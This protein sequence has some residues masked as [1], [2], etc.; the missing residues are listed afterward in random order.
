MDQV[1]E[2]FEFLKEGDFEKIKNLFEKNPKLINEKDW[3]E[4][5]CLHIVAWSDKTE[6]NSVDIIEY[7]LQK[8]AN[9]DEKDIFKC[10]PL[11][12]ASST[13]KLDL[14]KFLINKRCLY[15]IKK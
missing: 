11:Y 15:F 4:Q 2:W 5:N 14:V 1:K 12:W 7:F 10:T 6:K 3:N 9:I 13:G 8:N